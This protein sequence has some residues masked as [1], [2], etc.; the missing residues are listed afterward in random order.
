MFDA[1]L[2]EGKHVLRL[3]VSADR[4]PKSKGTAIRI[5]QFA[6]NGP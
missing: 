6:V 2:E 4:N 5:L 3:W 1:D